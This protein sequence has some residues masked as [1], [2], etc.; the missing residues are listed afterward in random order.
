MG[1][2]PCGLHSTWQSQIKSCFET[3]SIRAT[4]G[5]P[6]DDTHLSLQNL[7]PVERWARE[8]RQMGNKKKVGF[9]IDE[10]DEKTW[11]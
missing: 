11:L 6:T 5:V 7:E 3:S 1:Q 4:H 8:D 9:I 2:D 10:A